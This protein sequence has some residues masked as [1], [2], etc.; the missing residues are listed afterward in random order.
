MTDAVVVGAGPNGLSAAITLARKGFSVVVLEANDTIGG[1]ARTRE[2]TL[3]GFH[4]DICS[5]IHPMSV[6]SPFMMSIPLAEHGL[7]WKYSHGAVAHPL[8]DG[9][10]GLLEQS[11]DETAEAL[12]EDAAAYRSL[13]GALA[14]HP[15]AVFDEILRPI[16]LIPR[17]PLL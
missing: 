10:A 15:A 6:V 13:M 17:H 11:L 7:A 16:R 3:P 9:T 14:K 1:G 5:A 2:L 4:H 8:D 12:G